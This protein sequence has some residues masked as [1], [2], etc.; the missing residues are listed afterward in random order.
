MSVDVKDFRRFVDDKA[1]EAAALKE[2]E[3]PMLPQEEGPSELMTGDPKLDKV[4]RVLQ[5]NIKAAE[6]HL[7]DLA[8][9]VCSTVSPDMKTKLTLEY[10]L[11]KGMLEA[12]KAVQKLPAAIMQES[13]RLSN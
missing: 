1:A 9:V 4:V 3:K 2:V 11:A 13:K 8:H 7:N 10:M 12:Y 6:A 5:D